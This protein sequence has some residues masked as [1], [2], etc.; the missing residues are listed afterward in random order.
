MGEGSLPFQNQ[1]SKFDAISAHQK[2]KNQAFSIG[3]NNILSRNNNFF[4]ED[5]FTG[6]NKPLPSLN[7]QASSPP[8]LPTHP[9]QSL[10]Y[11]QPPITAQV[12]NFQS[13]NPNSNG[14]NGYTTN[15][16]QDPRPQGPP[17][18]EAPMF[19]QSNYNQPAQRRTYESPARN[20][21]PMGS[22]NRDTDRA[23]PMK[24]W[25]GAGFNK[26]YYK[27]DEINNDNRRNGDLNK[28]S[29]IFQAEPETSNWEYQRPKGGRVQSSG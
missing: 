17:R 6:P 26:D 19:Q 4:T 13:F 12:Q 11:S 5:K 1:M 7:L 8:S 22:Y 9:R 25:S 18:Q 21:E 27:T 2:K 20:V 28:K 24:S 10:T 29:N 23:A 3:A 16:P 15:P 14:L